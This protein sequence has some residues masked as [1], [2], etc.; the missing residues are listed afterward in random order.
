VTNIV[1][2]GYLIGWVVTSIALALTTRHEFRPASIVVVA[3]AAWPL[4]AIGAVQFVAVALVAEA[5]RIRQPG[6]KSIDEALD[7]LLTEWAIGDAGAHDRRLSVATG[8]D[9]AHESS[10]DTSGQSVG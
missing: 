8:S 3:G 2:Y 9:N 1:L 10:V 4:L 5:A 6:P 7:E